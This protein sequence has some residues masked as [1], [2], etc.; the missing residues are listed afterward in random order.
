MR[1]RER[2]RESVGGWKNNV[3]VSLGGLKYLKCTGGGKDKRTS[4]NL[5]K[6]AV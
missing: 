5:F 1:E 4:L 3:N 6:L 2:E